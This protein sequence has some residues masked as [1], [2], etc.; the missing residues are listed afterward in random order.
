MSIFIPRRQRY[1][2]KTD[3]HLYLDTSS[4]FVSDGTSVISFM[5]P[6]PF[7]YNSGASL[8][9]TGTSEYEGGVTALGPDSSLLITDPDLANNGLEHTWAWVGTIHRFDA[10]GGLIALT[11]PANATHILGIQRS[12]TSSEIRLYVNNIASKIAGIE[13]LLSDGVEH[14]HVVSRNGSQITWIMDGEVIASLACDG[15]PVSDVA[16]SKLY[17]GESRDANSSNAVSDWSIFLQDATHSWDI[18]KAKRFSEN[19]YAILKS[20]RKYF[21]LG[22]APAHNLSLLNNTAQPTANTLSLQQTHAL[23]VSNSIANAAGDALLIAQ[24]QQLVISDASSNAAAETTQITQSQNIV[25]ADSASVASANDAAITQTHALQL[26]NAYSST[27]AQAIAVS[28]GSTHSV[29]LASASADTQSAS[30]ALEQL[31]NVTL[32]D[33]NAASSADSLAVIV[34]SV[35]QLSFADSHATSQASALALQ[36]QHDLLV[37]DLA[38]ASQADALAIIQTQLLVFADAIANSDAD[39]LIV[40]QGA[41]INLTLLGAQSAAHS[42]VIALQQTQSLQISG[43][44]ANALAE[45]LAIQQTQSLILSNADA[46]AVAQAINV[47]GY[48]LGQILNPSIYSVSVQRDIHSITLKRSINVLH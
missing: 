29:S 20:R 33:A 9:L 32:D 6:T 8:S 40:S 41:V 5:S 13:G 4:E 30:F 35:H 17:F 31:H 24:A 25:L 48:G 46:Q 45:L 26:T 38:A 3:G 28:V 39:V 23:N 19:P 12:T 27:I 11:G 22:G 37:T 36:Q 16:N 14:V 18:D 44:D 34:G 43:A 21:S 47:L 10:W 7:V 42:D 15:Q 2:D 1:K